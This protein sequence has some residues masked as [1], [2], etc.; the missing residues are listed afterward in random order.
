MQGMAEGLRPQSPPPVIYFSSKA[1]TP[2]SC[3]TTPP[4][5]KQLFKHMS[6]WGNSRSH[7][8]ELHLSPPGLGIFLENSKNKKVVT[9]R[10]ILR[11]RDGR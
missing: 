5:R 11:A 6:L 10:K 1:A 2:I 7:N 4:T 9:L 8:T 3:Q